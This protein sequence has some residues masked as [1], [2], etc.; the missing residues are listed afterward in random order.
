MSPLTTVRPK[1]SVPVRGLLAVLAANL[2]LG[3]PAYF[4]A[5]LMAYGFQDPVALGNHVTFLVLIAIFAVATGLI[6]MAVSANGGPPA[7]AGRRVRCGVLASLALNTAVV[8]AGSIVSAQ[9]KAENSV[10]AGFSTTTD[11][12]VASVLFVMA[13]VLTLAAVRVVSSRPR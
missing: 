3:V 13:I 2:L 7:T 11:V 8:G 10:S 12:L 5:F 1:R 4:T 9:H 6:G